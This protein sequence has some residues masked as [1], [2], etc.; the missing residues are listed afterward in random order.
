M[1]WPELLP[2]AS[3]RLVEPRRRAWLSGGPTSKGAMRRSLRWAITCVPFG[4]GVWP[5]LEV[6]GG[7][8]WM[9][10]T[11]M[12]ALLPV[13]G[14]FMGAV[15]AELAPA[16]AVARNRAL[17]A[18]VG[19]VL[20][21]VAIEIMPG[22]LGVLDGW[23]VA[24]AFSVGGVLYL[25][26]DAAVECGAG[27]GGGRQWMIYVA[28]AA[29]LFGDGLMIG[30]GSTVAT[31]VA[32]VLAVGQI[33][34]DVPEGW[35]TVATLRGAGVARVRRLLLSA[36]LVVPAVVGA[37]GSWWLLRDRAPQW[38]WAALVATAGL[39]AVAVF[40]DMI[41]EAHEGAEDTSISTLFL[42]TGFAGFTVVA[43]A[44]G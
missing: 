10:V 40:E 44:V 8:G 27:G 25:G 13:A 29:D 23:E 28:V 26:I 12:L 30:A 31:D 37:A 14:N 15:A 42:L 1:P 9:L 19:V 6:D 38:Q 7:D 24:A 35:A 32:L 3:Y 4:C 34:A 39:F 18:A 2:C 16:S 22:A 36:A 33:L 21:V 41:R 5:G 17:H 20:G 43:T 11:L